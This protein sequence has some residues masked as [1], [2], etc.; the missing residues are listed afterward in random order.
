MLRKRFHNQSFYNN[1]SPLAMNTSHQMFTQHAL[2]TFPRAG[3]L[4]LQE[5]CYILGRPCRLHDY[6]IRRATAC[7]LSRSDKGHAYHDRLAPTSTAVTRVMHTMIGLPRPQP[8]LS[9]NDILSSTSCI[10][11]WHTRNVVFLRKLKMTA[12]Q[13]KQKIW[14]GFISPSSPIFC[15]NVTFRSLLVETR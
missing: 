9:F 12:N 5:N 10:N 6:Y 2:W 3:L 1:E 4:K 8:R 15:P 14:L 7:H 11:A 13:T